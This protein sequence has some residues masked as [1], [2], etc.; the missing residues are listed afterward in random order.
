MSCLT[1]APDNQR[2]LS[3]ETIVG[4]ASE[5]LH[6]FFDVSCGICLCIF[7]VILHNVLGI[8]T[9]LGCNIGLLCVV[10]NKELVG[11]VLC[12]ELNAIGA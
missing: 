8:E 1:S 4:S 12:A 5:S 7:K 3:F 2:L 11:T 6:N 10:D 9:E